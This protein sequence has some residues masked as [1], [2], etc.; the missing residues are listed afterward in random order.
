MTKTTI[1][2]NRAFSGQMAHNHG[3]GIHQ[4]GVLKDE[5]T[6]EILPPST[7]G[8]EGSMMLS[9]NIGGAGLAE[10]YRALHIYIGDE[11]GF[12]KITGRFYDVAGERSE[13]D[14]ADM[15]R[16]LRGGEV[17]PE[18]Y[19]II[20]WKPVAG[21]KPGEVQAVVRMYVDGKDVRTV[22]VGNG[23]INA[24]V[25]AIKQLAG[26]EYVAMSE[27]AGDADSRGSNAVADIRVE[28]SK[29]GWRTLGFAATTDV[30]ESSL[31]AFVD[32]ANR[33]RYMEEHVPRYEKKGS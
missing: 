4:D 12:D 33:L 26:R 8:M 2:P 31:L 5:I 29:N 24:G 14:H 20:S 18:Y 28:L 27:W 3:A 21:D 15:I 1:S 25:N 9:V 17:I 13:A 16:A 22:G 19:K 10:H 6:Y 11:E 32:G 23:Y 7:V 30:I